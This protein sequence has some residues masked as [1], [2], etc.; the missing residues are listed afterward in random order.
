MISGLF[1]IASYCVE[2]D[3]MNWQ[4]ELS[5]T[6]KNSKTKR[7]AYNETKQTIYSAFFFYYMQF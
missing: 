1:G 6:R 5:Q 4:R 2:E 3:N 7:I